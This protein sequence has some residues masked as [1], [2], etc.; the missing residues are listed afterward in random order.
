MLLTLDLH[1]V[2]RE[3]GDGRE[4]RLYVRVERLRRR[5]LLQGRLRVVCDVLLR[6]VWLRLIW[7]LRL[8]DREL[9][10]L[11][12]LTARVDRAESAGSGEG[13]L[14]GFGSGAG[15][16]FLPNMLSSGLTFVGASLKLEPLAR[17]GGS[18]ACC[19]G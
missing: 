2:G 18:A 4:E 8:R 14:A 13:A 17:P 1:L 15:A 11:R 5:W 6:D 12:L 19:G 10:R 7:N 9:R 3:G 16:A